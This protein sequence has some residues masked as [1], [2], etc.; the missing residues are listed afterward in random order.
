MKNSKKWY[1]SKTLKLSIATAVIGILMS[2]SDA[3]TET[4]GDAGV[5][6]IIIAVANALMR[7]VTSQPIK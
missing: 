3:I 6:V 2:V 1:Q 5:I 4:G 7:L